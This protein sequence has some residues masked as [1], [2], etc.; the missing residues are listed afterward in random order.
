[1]EQ[2]SFQT[3]QEAQALLQSTLKYLLEE[4]T[5]GNLLLQ[6]FLPNVAP[7]LQS[8]LPSAAQSLEVQNKLRQLQQEIGVMEELNSKLTK[9]VDEAE[10]DNAVLAT[11]VKALSERVDGLTSENEN[12]KAERKEF[13]EGLRKLQSQRR[14]DRARLLLGSAAFSF[15]HRVIE[16][17]FGAAE[18]NALRKQ[19]SSLQAIE[20]HATK[21]GLG[22]KYDALIQR[23]KIDQDNFDSVLNMARSERLKL[24]HPT[25]LTEEEEGDENSKPPTT[26]Q[27]KDQ[28]E[29]VFIAKKYKVSKQ[30]I[31]AMIDVLFELASHQ[32]KEILEK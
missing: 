21:L 17:I 12:L 10:K 14:S 22:E 30:V 5:T 31:S 16:H 19:L 32:G 4:P 20:E 27:L 26:Q 3:N 9:R 7:I 13:Y 25:R 29:L 11:K 28:A 23:Y 15:L 8:V 2:Y 6:A 1:M 24:A 18:M